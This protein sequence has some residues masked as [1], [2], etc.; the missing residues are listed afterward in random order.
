MR[1]FSISFNG[2]QPTFKI[3]QTDTGTYPTASTPTDTITFTGAGGITI[4]GNSAT[5]T[6]TITG[7]GG[8]SPAGS[9]GDIQFNTAGAFAAD[10][11]KLFWDVTNHRL[12]LGTS[13][14]SE[15]LEVYNGS[16][17]INIGHLKFTYL[18]N[19]SS[20]P[21][22]SAVATGTGNCTNGVHKV[23][24]TYVTASGESDS[25]NGSSNVTVDASHK[26]ISVSSISVGT[27]GVVTARKVYMTK[28]GGTTYYFVSTINDNTTTTLTINTADSSLTTL[29]PLT[30]STAAQFIVGGT[31]FAA[32]DRNTQRLGAIGFT[33][34]LT[35]GNGTGSEAFGLGSSA[36]STGPNLA[37]GYN[38]VVTGLQSTSIGPVIAG[39]SGTSTLLVGGYHTSTT[40]SYATAV[41]VNSFISGDNAVVV[42]YGS[43]ASSLY[44]IAIGAQANATAQDA[45]TIG[46]LSNATYQRSVAIGS[47]CNTFGIDMTCIKSQSLYLGGGQG[48]AQSFNLLS[49]INTGAGNTNGTGTPLGICSGLSTGS[50]AAGDIYFQNAP[51]GSSGTS[52]NTHSD[53]L[54]IYGDAGNGKAKFT[55]IDDTPAPPTSG[56][57]S[58]HYPDGS[59]YTGYTTDGV[60]QRSYKLYSSKLD[61][62]STPYYTPYP[63]V[64]NTLTDNN[65]TVTIPDPSAANSNTTYGI[66]SGSYLANNDARAYKVY[67]VGTVNGVTVVDS[68]PATTSSSPNQLVY[69][70]DPT[71]ASATQQS[72]GNYTP[73]STNTYDYLIYAHAVYDSRDIYSVT[74][75][76]CTVTGDG[77]TDPFYLA[78]TWTEGTFPTGASVTDYTI[79]QQING[80]GFD[81]YISGIAPGG[82]YNDTDPA[83]WIISTPTLTPTSIYDLAKVTVTW[84]DPTFLSDSILPASKR[85]QIVRSVAG[86]GFTEQLNTPINFGVNTFD[87]TNNSLW[88]ATPV[89]TPTSVQNFFKNDFFWTAA[90]DANAYKMLKS[91]NN[92]AAI[93][94]SPATSTGSPGITYG[95]GFYT[96]NGQVTDYKIWAYQVVNSVTI[97]ASTRLDENVT[98]DNSGLSYTINLTWTAPT[99]SPFATSTGY[100][101]QRQINSGGYTDYRNVTALFLDDDNTGWTTSTPTLTPIV[102]YEIEATDIPNGATSAFVDTGLLPWNDSITVTPTAQTATTVTIN[103]V[104]AAFEINGNYKIPA[105]APPA[106]DYVLKSTG[107]SNN[108]MSW[109][110]L[111]LSSLPGTLSS[112]Q[113]ALGAPSSGAILYESAGVFGVYGSGAFDFGNLYHTMRVPTVL[114]HE[115]GIQLTDNAGAAQWQQYSGSFGSSSH[116]S[117]I[118]YN[119]QSGNYGVRFVIDGDRDNFLFQDTN[120]STRPDNSALF[121]LKSTTR[122]F[123]FPRMTTTQRNAIASPA[124]GL[125]VRDTSLALFYEY[126]GS[127]WSPLI[128]TDAALSTSDI[129]TNNVST[130]KH[131]FAPKAPNDATQYLDGTATYSV[132]VGAFRPKF[133]HFA[134]AGNSTT[135]K[136]DLY[137]DTLAAGLLATNGDKIHACYGGTFVSSATA[138]RE[139]TL[140]FGGTDIF[141]TGTLTL[142]ASTAWTLYADIIRVSSSVVRYM[143][144]LTT[145]GAALAAYTSVGELTGLTLSNTQVLKITGQAAG[146]GAATNDIVAKMGSVSFELH[147]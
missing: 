3:F 57:D 72:G 45:I 119:L 142:S 14:P 48:T 68:N 127:A 24:F 66:G 126:T 145:Q 122:G 6:I 49:A 125:V 36:T 144:S 77:T 81:R 102:G 56:T 69:S 131:G 141:D 118:Q 117:L 33:T 121:D 139:I 22:V 11:G 53:R 110:S 44:S 70:G 107:T 71:G 101:I 137:S 136:T 90:T 43:Q 97:Y 65:S 80:G 28:A 120:G 76:S 26:Q 138:T 54:R 96:A 39:N 29:M 78:L 52:Q 31:K 18:S 41:G 95:S 129:T 83:N 89:T 146:V 58:I 73:A 112:T 105:T 21:S 7:S 42:G 108:L 130:S 47:N 103:P 123:L 15:E 37:V 133:D 40:A 134:D 8:G 4:A 61:L 84:T 143:I 20:A 23:K 86:G 98:D 50:G 135:T 93:S 1:A 113:I 79:L 30:N 67:S 12:G 16:G 55:A 19:P 74:P 25:S 34:D 62:T 132:P 124:A 10:T 147:A 63:F 35:F 13:S 115:A 109:Q 92:F 88:G 106:A 17:L 82:T 128:T 5:K 46:N 87:D 111:A 100:I 99:F 38:A 94:T 75:A 114:A 60:T 104:G 85:I 32:F 64:F 51:A 91:L 2:S 59:F 9:S 116:T 27:S 140:S